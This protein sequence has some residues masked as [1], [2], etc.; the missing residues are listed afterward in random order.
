[1]KTLEI[2]NFGII[3]S[4]NIKLNGLTVIAGNNDSG[5]STVGKLLFSIIKAINKRDSFTEDEKEE[6]VSKKIK[7]LYL[8]VS[9]KSNIK[10]VNEVFYPENIYNELSKY[11]KN[12]LFTDTEI[13]KFEAIFNDLKEVLI[14]NNLFTTYTEKTLLEI[15]NLVKSEDNNDEIVLNYLQDNFYSEFYSQI[16]PQISPQ[17]ADLET[18]IEYKE[19]DIDLFSVNIKNNKINSINY[20]NEPPYFKDATIIETPFSLQLSDLII[21]ADIIGKDNNPASVRSKTHFHI[22]DLVTKIKNAEYFRPNNASEADK[23]FLY[24]INKIISGEFYYDP[25]KQTFYYQKEKIGRIESINTASGIKTFGFFQLLLKSRNIYT[26]NLIIIDEPENHLHPEWQLKYA[27]MIVELV[28]NGISVVISSHSPYMLQALKLYSEQE[29]LKE[30]TSFY[31]AEEMNEQFVNII[32][33]TNDLNTIFSKLAK[34]FK[35]L[36]WA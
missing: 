11:I 1:M 9:N 19:G 34:P 14:T 8:F 13:E 5:K 16:S 33:K 3:K 21:N 15:K 18:F 27:K 32:E 22:K 7:E 2:K 26:K 35:E 12:S 36:V 31:L 28:K 24:K 6:D 23:D 30:R 10:S 29:G 20:Y 17:N 4:A 25:N